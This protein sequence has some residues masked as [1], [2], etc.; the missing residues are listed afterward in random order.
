MTNLFEHVCSLT[1]PCKLVK[2]A[3]LSGTSPT[4]KLAFADAFADVWSGWLTFNGSALFPV[5]RSL[6]CHLD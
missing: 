1:C 5:N 6:V 4:V 2:L 3:A